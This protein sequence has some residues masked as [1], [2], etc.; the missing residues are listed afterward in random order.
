MADLRG[1]KVESAF[2]ISDGGVIEV[3]MSS[4]EERET[5]VQKCITSTDTW[6]PILC[7]ELI[8]QREFLY[9][10]K[11]LTDREVPMIYQEAQTA[12]GGGEIYNG[13]MH[14]ST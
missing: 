11:D 9:S 7:T 6:L 1:L 12:S 2:N 14:G 13:M 4:A 10:Q 5:G 8:A 3:E